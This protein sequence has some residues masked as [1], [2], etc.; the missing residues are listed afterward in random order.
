MYNDKKK[1]NLMRELFWFFLKGHQNNYIILKKIKKTKKHLDNRH[2]I[3][4]Y[5]R[6]ELVILP[7][8]KKNDQSNHKISH[9][10]R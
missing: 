2:Y 9:T 10:M 1:K 3:F 6:V 8:N 4:F 5:F 7:C